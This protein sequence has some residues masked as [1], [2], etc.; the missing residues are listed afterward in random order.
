MKAL[1]HSI[2]T[3]PVFPPTQTDYLSEVRNHSPWF[4]IMHLWPWRTLQEAKVLPRFSQTACHFVFKI[5]RNLKNRYW[6]L[7]FHGWRGIQVSSDSSIC[8]GLNDVWMGGIGMKGSP[9][10]IQHCWLKWGGKRWNE[11]DLV[12]NHKLTITIFSVRDW[13]ISDAVFCSI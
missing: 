1:D 8:M 4:F 7:S 13:L 2:I 5:E 11:S 9:D 10:T 12:A 3:I 6:L